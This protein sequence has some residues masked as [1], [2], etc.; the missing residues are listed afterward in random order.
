MKYI[1]EGLREE[2]RAALLV[3]PRTR[4]QLEGFEDNAAGQ[5]KYLSKPYREVVT[6]LAC[7][8][9]KKSVVPLPAQAYRYRR[10]VK[11]LNTAPISSGLWLNYSY[12][13]VERSPSEL[14]IA[15]ILHEF[16]IKNTGRLNKESVELMSQLA[17]LA[18]QQFCSRLNSNT[19]QLTQ[20][21]IAKLSNK[22]IKAWEKSWASRWNSLLLIVETIDTRGLDH[23]YQRRSSKKSYPTT[24]QHV[25]VTLS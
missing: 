6:T 20:V 19:E 9:F 12:S 11:L 25:C 22:N 13:Y 17:I 14:I 4:G 24:S 18:C 21:E 8:T 1:A 23:V 7:R 16:Y 10:L 5:Q 2:L 3:V 15:E